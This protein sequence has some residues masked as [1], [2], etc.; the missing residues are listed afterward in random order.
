VGRTRERE[1]ATGRLSP[2]DAPGMVSEIRA[3][4]GTE[5]EW[6]GLKQ[7]QALWE[8]TQWVAQSR[9]ELGQDHAT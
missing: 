2:D 8:L 6:L 5:A 7:A 9:S 1:P 4:E 3:G